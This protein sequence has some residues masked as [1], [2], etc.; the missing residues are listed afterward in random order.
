MKI[1]YGLYIYNLWGVYML[2]PLSG[3][4][5]KD[6]LCERYNIPCKIKYESRGVEDSFVEEFRDV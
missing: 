5:L 3:S 1:E 4:D 2:V 6:M